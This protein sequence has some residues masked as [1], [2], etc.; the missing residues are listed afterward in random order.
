[1]EVLRRYG[2]ESITSAHQKW[3][4]NDNTC[5]VLLRDGDSDEPVGGVRLQRWGNGIPLAVEGALA[6]V[7]P[8]V[9]AWVAS[10]AKG[11]VGELCGLWCSP[12]VRG[13]GL[14]VQLTRMGIA[15]AAQAQT[16]TL[17]GLC[18]TRNVEANLRLG[19]AVDGTLAA[20]AGGAGLFGDATTL[21][22]HP[23]PHLRPLPLRPRLRRR[24]SRLRRPGSGG[25]HRPQGARRRRPGRPRHPRLPVPRLPRLRGTRPLAETRR[26]P[27]TV[28]QV[29]MTPTMSMPFLSKSIACLPSVF[30]V[31]L[32]ACAVGHAPPPAGPATVPPASVA[33]HPDMT[34]WRLLGD[35]WVTGQFER[36]VVRVG[37]HERRVARVMLVITH[38]NLEV[39]D[40][41]IQLDSGQRWSPGLR[42]SFGDGSRSRAIDLPRNARFIR[43]V[44][45][46]RGAV[47]P[48]GRTHVEIWGQ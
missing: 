40:V 48:G 31:A 2:I 37:K 26:D 27:S 45:L 1:M 43:G 19:F 24:R 14:G 5:A 17:F 46:V 39:G 28:K 23:T 25:A 33:G 12:R 38:S 16:N 10:F 30:L 22:D 6:R 3:W 7:D 20:V 36:Q 21:V 15:L 18:D 47:A 34:G 9:S 11:G 29:T 13:F 8:R 32:S 4:T 35:A 42:N 41:V 44:E